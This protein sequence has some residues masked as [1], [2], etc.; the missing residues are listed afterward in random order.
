MRK[1]CW[2][3]MCEVFTSNWTV[4]FP[5][6]Y[7]YVV[8]HY[9][10][11]LA[12]NISSDVDLEKVMLKLQLQQWNK[13]EINWILLPD[14]FFL[15]KNTLII[16]YGSF[17]GFHGRSPQCLKQRSQYE[18]ILIKLSQ[19]LRS[20]SIL[21]CSSMSTSAFLCLFFFFSEKSATKVDT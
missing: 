14:F 17:L 13:I 4:L 2:N 5:F 6:I 18:V 11:E 9:V 15:Q 1:N 7:S 16:S 19:K 3:W 8:M 20:T 21:Y 10:I 12:G